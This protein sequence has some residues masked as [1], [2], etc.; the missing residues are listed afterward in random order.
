M[1]LPSM[2][3]QF[4]VFSGILQ[5]NRE[6]RYLLPRKNVNISTFVLHLRK[7]PPGK[8]SVAV[9]Q[10]KREHR[11]RLLGHIHHILVDD[12]AFFPF[13]LSTKTKPAFIKNENK[14]NALYIPAHYCFPGRNL[15]PLT[16]KWRLK[17]DYTLRVTLLIMS[18]MGGHFVFFLFPQKQLHAALLSWRTTPAAI[19]GNH[20]AEKT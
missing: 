17:Q 13:M 6:L 15:E 12:G 8:P 9:N 11:F 3:G 7:V 16:K 20:V 2:L 19:A 14:Y 10:F 1:H 5:A 18:S 4:F